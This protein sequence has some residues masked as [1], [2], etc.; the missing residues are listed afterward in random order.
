VTIEISNTT[1]LP[2]KIYANEGIAQLIFLLALEVCEVSYADKSG[3]IRP[4][5]AL[6]SEDCSMP[7][8]EKIILAL[9]VP[10]PDYAIEIVDASRI[11]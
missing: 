3:S 6:P 11:T 8:R 7:V 1:P 4:R 9:D 10:D 5:R 2:A